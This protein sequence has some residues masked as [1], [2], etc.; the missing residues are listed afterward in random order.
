M[1]AKNGF[2]GFVLFIVAA[3]G[4]MLAQPALAEDA[5]VSVP[6]TVTVNI[7]NSPVSFPFGIEFAK[8]DQTVGGITGANGQVVVNFTSTGTWQVKH[9][10]PC[11]STP[12]TVDI[13]TSTNA[14][15]VNV[16]C[17]QTWPYNQYLPA[18]AAPKLIADVHVTINGKDPGFKFGIRFEQG[19]LATG[20][21]TDT[22]GH[23]QVE[24]PRIGTWAVKHDHPCPYEPK[25]VQISADTTSV[26]VKL[27]CK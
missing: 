1:N 2:L 22:A 9:N 15:T 8:G 3:F 18:V 10:H 16:T 26:E 21:T 19:N 17:R 13:T 6:V 23:I 4:I 14:L 27:T 25:Q 24:F 20:G 7:D 11:P 12:A 5:P